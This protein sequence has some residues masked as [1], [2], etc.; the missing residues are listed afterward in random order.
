[1]NPFYM[2]CIGGWSGHTALAMATLFVSLVGTSGFGLIDLFH[3]DAGEV[4]PSDPFWER[5][6]RTC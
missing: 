1:M 4:T 6:K 5:K 2:V 3:F